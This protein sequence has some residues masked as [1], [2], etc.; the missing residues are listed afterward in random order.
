M[1]VCAH[2]ARRLRNA[3]R[4]TR[5]GAKRIF[6]TLEDTNRA[7]LLNATD[8]GSRSRKKYTIK[9]HKS[10][11]SALARAKRRLHRTPLNVDWISCTLIGSTRRVKKIT[12][13]LAR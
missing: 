5:A 9:H 6:S 3:C 11:G 4:A 2:E 7:I 8:S 1:C 10:S 13:H 12:A